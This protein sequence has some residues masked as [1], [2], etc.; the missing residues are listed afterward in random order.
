MCMIATGNPLLEALARYPVRH[1]AAGEMILYQG[2]VPSSAF[3]LKKGIAKVYNISAQGD[4]KPVAFNCQPDLLASAWVFSKCNGALFFYEAHTD[5][6]VYAVPRDDFLNLIKQDN[7]VLIQLVD[8]YVSVIT[9]STL[10][11]HALEFSKAS[12][13]IIHMLFYLCQAH[14]IE[15]DGKITIDL[16]LTQQELANLLGLTR[17]TTGIELLKLKR[18]GLLTLSK[19]RYKIDREQL[20][21]LI[22]ETEFDGVRLS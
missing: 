2:E 5:C 16:P 3:V 22:G 1:F 8:R 4:E 7:A 20:M 13:K 9:A 17:E 11:L 18:D 6:E 21:K 12:D 15:E 14:G 10:Q 19:K